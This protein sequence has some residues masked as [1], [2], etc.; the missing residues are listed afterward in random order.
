MNV[1]HI[2]F[3]DQG[4]GAEEFAYSLSHSLNNSVLYVGKKHG[5]SSRVKLIPKANISSFFK[6]LDKVTWKVGFKRS[7][8]SLL[9]IQDMGHFTY[10][11]LKNLP[12]FVNADII[13]LHNIHGE[14][15]N[16]RA[17]SKIATVKPIVWTLHDMW[18]MTGGEG[19]VFEGMSAKQRLNAYPMRNPIFDN[20]TYLKKLKRKLIT[21]NSD[22][23]FLVAPSVHHQVRVSKYLI[24]QV[25][26]LIY[27]GIDLNFFSSIDRKPSIIPSVLI[28]NSKSIYKNSM[29]VIDAILNTASNFQLH[30]IGEKLELRDKR[31]TVSNHGFIKSREEI[32]EL[33]EKIDIAAF[34][35]NE[36]TFGLLPA[37]LAASGVLV[38]LNKSLSVFREHVTLYGA[39][40]YEDEV[41]LTTEID[42]AVNQI[43]TTREKGKLSAD[44]IK[45]NFNRTDTVKKYEQLYKKVE[46]QWK[47]A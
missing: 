36:E 30:V 31:I 16:L 23:I 9:G 39:V 24:S 40:L 6:F 8:R 37:E 46:D 26:N 5:I 18:C 32:A 2:N 10:D 34:W 19:F 11:A 41:D 42:N 44:A 15:F 7:F 45:K 38:F 22:S 14:F 3:S 35:S 27:Y 47:S 25:A 1:F 4:G 17:V 21:E 33:F 29:K 20:R 12:D 43:E 13:H 28:F